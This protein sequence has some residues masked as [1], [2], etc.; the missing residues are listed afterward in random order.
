MPKTQSPTKLAISADITIGSDD[1]IKDDN[2]ISRLQN[3]TLNDSQSDVEEIEYI[4]NDA[5]KNFRLATIDE[6]ELN[7]KNY[8]KEAENGD[9][10]AMLDVAFCYYVGKGVPKD[11]NTGFEWAKQSAEN[12]NS[13]AML[14]V[15][16][17]Y[18]ENNGFKKLITKVFEYYLQ[19]EEEETSDSIIREY[20]TNQV[21]EE[22]NFNPEILISKLLTE[23]IT[24][25]LNIEKNDKKAFEWYL[26]AAEAGNTGGMYFVAFS[27]ANG[28]GVQ[29]NKETSQKW[30]TDVY[31]TVIKDVD[32]NSMEDLL[33]LGNFYLTEYT[34]DIN[35][36]ESGKNA[37]K[38]FSKC[39]D[40][41][42]NFG[43][44]CTGIC[45]YQG[46]G[47][48]QNYEKAF[49]LFSELARDSSNRKVRFY[50]DTGNFNEQHFEIT[51]NSPLKKLAIFIVG[52]CYADG[53]GVSQDYNK[54]FEYFKKSAE[55]GYTEAMANVGAYY[56]QG[57]GV[58]KDYDQAFYWC[59]KAAESGNVTAM[60][61]VGKI[62][63]LDSGSHKDY[64]RAVF[65]FEKAANALNVDAMKNL[66]IMYKN[67][68][69]V[70]KNLKKSKEWQQKY[71]Q[72]QK[73][74][75]HLKAFKES[76]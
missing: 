42:N 40:L 49:E 6:D 22:D 62:Y 39:A 74:F 47:T 70:A 55:L 5:T 27:Y 31:E 4:D 13:N 28:I 32:F 63:Y 43:I 73:S 56:W 8:L 12:G 9:T 71:E 68:E 17:A 51:N 54:A 23:D 65:W 69:G 35:V 37:F 38:Y 15:G 53:K 11:L 29:K 16:T 46:I 41:R 48:V 21:T 61:T 60:N 25:E 18:T 72:L 75:S 59:L 26:K 44:L 52:K 10:D 58:E 45:H 66:A 3:L 50:D 67:G 1:E 36:E 57:K 64:E 34:L 33:W 20:S 19:D 76:S 7:F 14:L 30:L 2:I 24:I